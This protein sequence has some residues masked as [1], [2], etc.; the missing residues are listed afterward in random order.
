MNRLR[1]PLLC[2]G[3][4]V[5]GMLTA[6]ALSITLVAGSGYIF[7]DGHLAVAIDALTG[8]GTT[9]SMQQ[10]MLAG[11]YPYDLDVI[12]VTHSDH[13]H[14]DA[15]LVAANMQNQTAS[16]VVG[17]TDVIEAVRELAPELPEARFVDVSLQS[18]QQIPVGFDELIL[19]AFSFPHPPDESRPN[20]G[21]LLTFN[22]IRLFHPGDL[23]YTR[24]VERFSSYDLASFGID[25]AFLPSFMFMDGGL[26]DAIN[27]LEARCFVPTHV[28]PVALS[29]TCQQTRSVFSNVL[30]FQ[31]LGEEIE[32]VAGTSCGAD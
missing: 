15:S 4:I 23:D 16:V 9:S 17:P 11:D 14:F 21:Y 1:A 2:L 19:S 31:H 32:Y 28:R 3:L 27:G 26:A 5:A 6:Q 13:D 20:L 10:S 7:R 22:T 25:V 12:L 18:G 30:C 24:A 29:R 8:Y